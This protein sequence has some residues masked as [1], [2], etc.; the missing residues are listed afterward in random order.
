MSFGVW[1]DTMVLFH[2]NSYDGGILIRCGTFGVTVQDQNGWMTFR[3]KES[4]VIYEKLLIL[5]LNLVALVIFSTE[6]FVQHR[7][8]CCVDPSVFLGKCEYDLSKLKEKWIGF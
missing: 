5:L 7:T 6:N 3:G 4:W 1:Y 2:C 8:H